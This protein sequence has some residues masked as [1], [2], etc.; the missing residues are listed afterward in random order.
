MTEATSIDLSEWIEF[1][2]R[3]TVSKTLLDA[4]EARITLFCMTAGQ[5]LTE[6]T[7]AKPATVHFTEGEGEFVMAGKSHA[8][9][10][11]AWFY[12]PKGTP[13]ALKARSNI[14]FVLTLLRG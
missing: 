2:D 11:G 1:A 4:P 8:I 5:E 10:P 3:G 14:V 7:A 12:M 6:H 9:K 13:H